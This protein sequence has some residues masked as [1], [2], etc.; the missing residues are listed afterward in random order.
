VPGDGPG[1]SRG[2]VTRPTQIG[3]DKHRAQPQQLQR[4]SILWKLPRGWLR[5]EP[6]ATPK[7]A[8]RRENFV[9]LVRPKRVVDQVLSE[10]AEA[11]M[12]DEQRSPPEQKFA[13]F[14]RHEHVTEVRRI[15][16]AVQGC[17]SNPYQPTNGR[18]RPRV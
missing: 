17:V 12:G 4:C 10:G 7:E 1:A 11:V 5:I 14:L 9:F 6:E 16:R 18:I 15:V 8:T 3:I 2:M 13:L